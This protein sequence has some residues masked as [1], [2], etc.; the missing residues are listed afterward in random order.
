MRIFEMVQSYYADKLDD[1]REVRQSMKINLE[2]KRER[3]RWKERWLDRIQNDMQIA[4]VTKEE[5]R[6]RAQEKKMVNSSTQS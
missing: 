3:G 5:V 2:G 4:A 1:P 6:D